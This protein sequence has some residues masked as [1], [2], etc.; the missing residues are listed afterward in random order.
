MG[1]VG[2]DSLGGVHGDS[3]AVGS[4]ADS[5]ET[6]TSTAVQSHGGTVTLVSVGDLGGFVG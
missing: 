3:E 6:W 2:G 5:W 4:A 1:G